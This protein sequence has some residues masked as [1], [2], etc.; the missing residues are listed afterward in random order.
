MPIIYLAIFAVFLFQYLAISAS[1][2][3]APFFKWANTPALSF[4]I[5]AL[6]VGKSTVVPKVKKF[7]QCQ[8]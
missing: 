4:H 3:E 6:F 7:W 2:G 1:L 5:Y 8:D